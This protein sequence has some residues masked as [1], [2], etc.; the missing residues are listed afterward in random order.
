DLHA[1][2]ELLQRLPDVQRHEPEQSEREQRER[3]R[4]HAQCAEKRRPL[5]VVQHVTD[6]APHGVRFP[7]VAGSAE[8]KTI[9]PRAIS[10]VRNSLRRISSRLCVAMMIDVP[11]ALISRRSWKMPRVARSSRLPVGSSA[12]S[13]NGSFTSARAIAA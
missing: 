6:R 11:C 13:A 8:S 2:L 3:D 5:E 10:I 4:R 7:G 1:V 9:C 12:M